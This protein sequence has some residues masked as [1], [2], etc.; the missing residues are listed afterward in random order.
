MTSEL[1]WQRNDALTYF[2]WN[3]NH[4]KVKFRSKALRFLQITAEYKDCPVFTVYV[5]IKSSSKKIL[6]T[7]SQNL[8]KLHKHRGG[9]CKKKFPWKI[10]EEEFPVPRNTAARKISNGV[11]SL[12]WQLRCNSNADH[13]KF[14]SLSNTAVVVFFQNLC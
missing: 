4:Y 3:W 8:L 13:N 10:L 1:S 6:I 7:F 14:L 12:L 9:Y 5:T 11:I 2:N